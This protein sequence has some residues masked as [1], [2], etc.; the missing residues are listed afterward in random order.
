MPTSITTQTWVS[1]CWR[2]P[3]TLPQF[4]HREIGYWQAI[5]DPPTQ[6]ALLLLVNGDEEILTRHP[7]ERVLL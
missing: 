5:G 6:P 3:Y 1:V 7:F 2:L 4:Q